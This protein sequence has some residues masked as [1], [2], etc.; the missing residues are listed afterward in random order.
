MIPR[1]C[2]D[3]TLLTRV[4][5]I[6]C[7]ALDEGTGKLVSRVDVGHP[8]YNVGLLVLRPERWL[9][10]SL[11]L[12]PPEQDDLHLLC[13]DIVL[14]RLPAGH[15]VHV[16]LEVGPMVLGRVVLH[17]CHQRQDPAWLARNNVLK[18]PCCGYSLLMQRAAFSSLVAS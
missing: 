17:H 3:D 6:R 15:V 16:Q 9:V 1:P 18:M 13:E 5:A 2:N 14:R 12:H 11:S 10:V 4:E 7:T 8:N